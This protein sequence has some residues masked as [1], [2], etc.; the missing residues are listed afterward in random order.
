VF[1]GNSLGL[2]LWSVA[3]MA[4]GLL[5]VGYAVKSGRR[6]WINVGK[7]SR[8]VHRSAEPGEFWGNVV[9]LVLVG[10]AFATFGLLVFTRVIV[11][12]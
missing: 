5:V 12:H 1:N 6:G 8:D 10:S 2:S 9:L 7:P 3:M 11:L 4:G